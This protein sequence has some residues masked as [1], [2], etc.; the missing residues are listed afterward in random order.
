MQISGMVRG[1]TRVESVSIW[2][3][4][5]L[6]KIE[7]RKRLVERAGATPFFIGADKLSGRLIGGLE[8]GSV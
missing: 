2:A 6:R 7:H 5:P 8:L 3:S 4:L 1:S